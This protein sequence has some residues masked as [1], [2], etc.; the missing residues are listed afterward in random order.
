MPN[1]PTISNSSCLIALDAIGRIE[2][3]RHLYTSI[4]VPDAVAQECGAA[5]PSWANVQ[6]VQNHPFVRTL[7]LNLGAGESEAIALA[8]ECGAD[9]L[10]LD[11]SKARKTAVQLQ[12]PVTGTLAIVLRAKQH[13][14]IATVRDVL[15]D[16]RAAGFF[17]SDALLQQV[18]NSAGE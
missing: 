17:V 9:R 8:V 10:I 7:R 4:V 2:I 6:S 5:M 15:D 18:L 11:D 16:L 13:G 12:L 14:H 3:L 1:G